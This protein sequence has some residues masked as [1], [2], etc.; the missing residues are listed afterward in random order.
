[1]IKRVAKVAHL[2][3]EA[4]QKNVFMAFLVGMAI[5]DRRRTN[6]SGLHC[7][8]AC[9]TAMCKLFNKLLKQLLQSFAP[10]VCSAQEEMPAV[11]W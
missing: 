7:F 1:M 11:T 2:I 4:S 6:F 8:L 3:K 9:S 10:V 5:C